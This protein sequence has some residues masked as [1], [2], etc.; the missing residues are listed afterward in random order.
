MVGQGVKNPQEYIPIV[1]LWRNAIG[2][3]KN[4][5]EVPWKFRYNQPH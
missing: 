5:I 2:F 3:T 1:I 4:L